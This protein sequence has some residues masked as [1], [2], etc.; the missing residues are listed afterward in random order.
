MCFFF[1]QAEDGIRD[2]TVTGVQTCAL[3]ILTHRAVALGLI[4]L[5]C[6]AAGLGAQ[7]GTG[8]ITGHVTDSATGRPVVAVRLSVVGTDRTAVTAEDGGFVLAA[9]PAGAHRRKKARLNTI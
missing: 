2:L 8:A 5:A 7:T 3:P 1:F 4:A 9:V 6:S